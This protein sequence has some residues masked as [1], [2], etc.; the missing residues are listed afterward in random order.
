MTSLRTQTTYF[1]KIRLRSQAKIDQHYKKNAFI[2][3]T[4][5]NIC[6]LQK[7]GKEMIQ[8]AGVLHFIKCI[9]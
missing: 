2:G 7:K 4:S 8:V 9:K 6:K 3:V 5:F 1:R